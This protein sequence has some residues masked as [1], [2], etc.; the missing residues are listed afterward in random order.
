MAHD[1][2]TTQKR[3]FLLRH[4]Q[5]KNNSGDGDKHRALSSKGKEDAAALGQNMTHKGYTP[6]LVLCSPALRTKQTWEGIEAFLPCENVLFL[7]RLYNGSTGDYL[8]EIQQ[9]E[10][11]YNNI[12]L[13]AHNPSIYELVILLGAQGDERVLSRLS[14]GYPPGSLS[15][16][17]C[18]CEKWADI[19][20]AVNTLIEVKNPMD[21]NAPAR[22]TRWM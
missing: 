11:K 13:I 15:I 17:E 3:L 12:L 22:P 1:E 5:A 2:R 18:A 14:E 21:Y 8:Y 19:Q 10:D 20:P 16:I 6:D 4:Q 7:D 9:I